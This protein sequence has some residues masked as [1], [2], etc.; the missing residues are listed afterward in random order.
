MYHV[1]ILKCADKTFYTGI[2]SDFARRV[3]EHN[4]S[5]LGAKYTRGRRPVKLVYSRKFKNKS[6]A[7]QEEYRIKQLTRIEKIN[8]IK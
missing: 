2:T 7:L 5:N 8:L 3:E 6:K 1:Y 4:F